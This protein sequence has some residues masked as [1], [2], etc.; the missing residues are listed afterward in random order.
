MAGLP[1]P[2]L[3]W[4]CLSALR[5][6]AGIN[7]STRCQKSSITSRDSARLWA[8]SPSAIDFN[9]SIL[10]IWK[11]V[12]KLEFV[13]RKIGAGATDELKNAPE[14]IFGIFFRERWQGG[15]LSS[16]RVTPVVD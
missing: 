8:N 2:G 10:M 1:A 15:Y 11:Q 6:R 5:C 16:G 9:G 4:Y 14:T 13:P 3:R 12:L 7:G